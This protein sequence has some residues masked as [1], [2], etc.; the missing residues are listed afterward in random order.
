VPTNREIVLAYD[1]DCWSWPFGGK[2]G[3]GEETVRVS[4]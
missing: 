1:E 4:V 2:L 3:A